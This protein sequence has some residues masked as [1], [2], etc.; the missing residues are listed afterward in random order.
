MWRTSERA[1]DITPGGW[2][3][4]LGPAGKVL[5]EDIQPQMLRMLDAN[6]KAQKVTN[7]QS[8]LGTEKDPRLPAGQV[9]LVLMVDVYH[10]FSDPV[11]MMQAIKRSL[12]P[13]GRVV[14]VEFRKEDDSVP[15]RPEHKM[16]TQQVRAELEPLGFKFD[17]V[18]EFLP[19]QH[20]LFFS[21]A[22]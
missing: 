12:K 8:I 6:M 10:E 14:L 3:E 16:T 17:K 11:A 1:S 5:A 9:D 4:S 15:I 19:W 22:K 13:D 7:V 21:L 18:L 20:I 2:R